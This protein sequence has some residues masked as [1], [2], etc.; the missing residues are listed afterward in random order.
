V[1]AAV[2]KLKENPTYG[3]DEERINQ[4]YAQINF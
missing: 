1:V 4:Q 2:W 3:T